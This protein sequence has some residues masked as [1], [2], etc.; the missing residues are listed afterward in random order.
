MIYLCKCIPALFSVPPPIQLHC[1][2]WAVPFWTAC[3]LVIKGAENFFLMTWD[4]IGPKICTTGAESKATCITQGIYKDCPPTCWFVSLG[5][6]KRVSKDHRGNVENTTI[7]PKCAQRTDQQNTC[8]CIYRIQNA[9]VPRC[10]WSRAQIWT[11][12][13]AVCRVSQLPSMF[14]HVHL[15]Q[16]WE[17]LWKLEDSDRPT[18]RGYDT[19]QPWYEAGNRCSF[20]AN[21]WH[22][23]LCC[24]SAASTVT[25]HQQSTQSIWACLE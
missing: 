25:S 2:Y 5:F 1:S 21:T 8:T 9:R 4:R 3:S 7:W 11:K 12:L 14:L 17:S 10:I 24:R 13:H 16:L 19:I 6:T 22:S 20:S 23:L 15:V 18:C